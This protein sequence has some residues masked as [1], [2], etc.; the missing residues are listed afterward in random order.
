MKGRHVFVHGFRGVGKTSLA[1]TAANVIQSPERPPIYVQC[2]PDGTLASFVHDILKQALPSDP[3]QAKTVT[4][5]TKSGGLGLWKFNLSAGMRNTVEQGKLPKPE[6][7]NDAVELLCFAM[8]RHSKRPV[9][10]IDEFDHMPK[11]EH[12][13]VDLL[14][15]KL[16]EVDNLP[17]KIIICGIGETL[18][19]LFAAHMSTYRYFHT[20]KLDRLD[21]NSCGRIDLSPFFHPPMSRVPVAFEPMGL[22]GA[23]GRGAEP[24]TKRSGPPRCVPGALRSAYSHG[25]KLPSALCGRTWL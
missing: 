21:L 8:E 1:Y 4:E 11:S 2:S 14:I 9:I 15:K 24:Y 12:I 23:T 3:T 25:D 5:S 6:S 22:G 18:E 13:N 16:A 17:L 19:S 7:I 10:I 20:I